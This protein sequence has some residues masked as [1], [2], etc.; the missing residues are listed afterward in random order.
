MSSEEFLLNGRKILSALYAEEVA[1]MEP[2]VVPPVV[3]PMAPSV[4]PPEVVTPIFPVDEMMDDG[5]DF[6]PLAPVVP[7]V[8]SPEVVTSLMSPAHEVMDEGDVA[9]RTRP[10]LTTLQPMALYD[11]KCYRCNEL[12]M[13]TCHLCKIPTHGA[14]RGC[15]RAIE[16]GTFA[17]FMC[18]DTDQSSSTAATATPSST[19]ATPAAPSTVPSVAPAAPFAAHIAAASSAP[20]ARS[21]AKSTKP[22]KVFC[23]RCN[24]GFQ[25]NYNLTRHRMNNVCRVA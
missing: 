23:G 25:Q 13:H 20:G 17:C 24:S 15:S 1:P 19:S 6:L 12:C 9:P 16:E 8:V 7:L 11:K 3:A 5:D 10:V 14:V 2:L 21:A 4:V 22:K 18:T